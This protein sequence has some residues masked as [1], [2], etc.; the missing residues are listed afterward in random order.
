MGNLEEGLR[1]GVFSYTDGADTRMKVKAVFEAPTAPYGVLTRGV[2][3]P[4]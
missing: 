1:S 3:S 4:A 2:G